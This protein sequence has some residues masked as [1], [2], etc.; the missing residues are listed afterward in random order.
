MTVTSENTEATP[1]R[2]GRKTLWKL[3]KPTVFLFA[4]LQ[5]VARRNSL[6][7]P[8]QSL[9]FKTGHRVFPKLT[10]PFRQRKIQKTPVQPC[11]KLAICVVGI[12]AERRAQIDL[13]KFNGLR[14]IPQKRGVAFVCQRPIKRLKAILQTEFQQIQIA[15]LLFLASG[16]SRPIPGNDYQER[17]F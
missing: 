15:T 2:K 10:A 3:M 5:H 17:T 11:P 7:Q 8:A 14:Q 1:C 12:E 16:A 4:Q 13:P 6:P 9:D